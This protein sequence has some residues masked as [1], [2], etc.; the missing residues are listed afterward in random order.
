[1]KI[2]YYHNNQIYSISNK[3]FIKGIK[4][5]NF[6]FYLQKSTKTQKR[7]NYNHVTHDLTTIQLITIQ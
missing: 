1:M 3:S 5:V 7:T 2:F 4:S 6:L